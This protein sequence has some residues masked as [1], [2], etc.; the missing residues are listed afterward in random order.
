MT[1][2]AA[3]HDMPWSKSVPRGYYLEVA[4]YNR[5]M[6]TSVDLPTRTALGE[7]EV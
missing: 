5:Q 1:M 3:L 6:G 2:W 7:K 4:G